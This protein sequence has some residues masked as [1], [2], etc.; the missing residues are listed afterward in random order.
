ML[1]GW[2]YDKQDWEYKYYCDLVIGSSWDQNFYLLT[3]GQFVNACA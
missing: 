1:H 3:K 2:E